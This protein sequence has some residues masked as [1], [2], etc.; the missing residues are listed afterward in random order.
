MPSTFLALRITAGLMTRWYY[1]VL[2]FLDGEVQVLAACVDEEAGV[3]LY[4]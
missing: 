3:R 1:I 4:L 2:L